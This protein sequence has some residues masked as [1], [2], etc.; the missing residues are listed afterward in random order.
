M[1]KLIS[2]C[3]VFTDDIL[4]VVCKNRGVDKNK[5]MNPSIKDV[6]H[7]SNLKNIDKAVKLFKTITKRET[8][9]V[10][11]VVDSDPD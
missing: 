3:N 11:I 7:Y 2:N 4:D 10:A 9:E 1:Y 5:I 6:I 8:S